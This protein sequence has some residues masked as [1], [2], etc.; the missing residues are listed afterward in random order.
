MCVSTTDLVSPPLDL[1]GERDQGHGVAVERH[2]DKTHITAEMCDNNTHKSEKKKRMKD[3]WERTTS[4]EE[5]EWART[6]S[7]APLID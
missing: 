2:A 1:F 6:Q 7:K 3:Y 4:T 5:I